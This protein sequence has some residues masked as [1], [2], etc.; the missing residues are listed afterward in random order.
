MN[1]LKLS[2][3]V[4][5]FSQKNDSDSLFDANRKCLK[6]AESLEY[7]T[8]GLIYT[9]MELGVT[10]EKEETRSKILNTLGVKVSNGSRPNLI[11]LTFSFPQKKTLSIEP[12]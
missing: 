4:F 10:Q 5:F 3:K 11:Q 7:E 1:R 12:R 8:D 2:I 9:P 6:H